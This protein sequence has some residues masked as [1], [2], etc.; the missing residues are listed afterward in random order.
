MHLQIYIQDVGTEAALS[1]KAAILRGTGN[2][3]L[4]LPPFGLGREALS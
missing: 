4:T 2:E 3:T 1:A